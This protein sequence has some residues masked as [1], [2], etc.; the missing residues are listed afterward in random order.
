MPIV[1]NGTTGITTPTY[2]GNVAAEYLV[3]VTGFKNR[4][5]NG[6]MT[7]DQR[8]NGASVT[9]TD[10]QYT[11]DR[12]VF[13]VG[14]TSKLTT[15]QNQGSVTPPTGFSNYLGITSSSAYTLLAGDYFTVAQ[16]IEGFN[17][18]DMAWG[19]ASA[20]TVTLSFWVRSSLT[21]TF[22]GTL[23]NSVYNRNYPF[24]YTILLANTWEQKSVT[25]AGDTSGTWVGATNGT[26]LSI[27]FSLGMGSTYSGTSGA[28]TSSVVFAPTGATSVV[29]T[30]GATWYI[31]GVQLE[32]GSVATSF[33]FRD[34]GRELILC[35][36]YCNIFY[37]GTYGSFMVNGSTFAFNIP[38]PVSMRTQPSFTTNINDSNFVVASPNSSQWAMYIQN[39]GWNSY[40]GSINTLSMNG[41]PTTQSWIQL[42]TYSC[43]LNAFTAFLLGSTR[44]FS[45]TAEL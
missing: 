33:D 2:N 18:A 32:K 23:N 8:N 22:G 37:G 15:Q 20:A 42:G 30:N 36:R 16:R 34:Y 10:G 29:G 11:L 38:M 6:A 12:W 35:Q 45:F 27:Q 26:G 17:F 21:G 44:Y 43:T 3:P 9:P 13:A 41:T 25:V 28:W 40:S 19:T 39:S 14:Q 4:I 5:I 31:T 1:L 24:T 7:I